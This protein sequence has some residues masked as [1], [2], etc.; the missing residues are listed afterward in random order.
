MTQPSRAPYISCYQAQEQ[1][2]DQEHTCTPHR[3][4]NINI[5]DIRKRFHLFIVIHIVRIDL[6][7]YYS[8]FCSL[9]FQF[10]TKQSIKLSEIE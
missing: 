4:I 7:I 3:H 10:R 9:R 8:S 2:Q 1:E 5:F 6:F